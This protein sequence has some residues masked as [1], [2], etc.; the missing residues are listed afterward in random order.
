M[1]SILVTREAR[2][3]TLIESLRIRCN[4]SWRRGL[5]LP[6]LM[7]VVLSTASV[8]L[9]DVRKTPILV[10]ESHTGERPKEIISLVSTLDDELEKRGFAA[11]AA[12]ILQVAA[13]LP[14]PGILDKSITAAQIGQQVEGGYDH[15]VHG[16]YHEA[17]AAE[18]EA[19]EAIQRNPALVVLN[20]S[21]A[22]IVL[23]AYTTLALS[24]AKIGDPD[25]SLTMMQAIRMFPTR[26]FPRA[27]YGPDDEKFYRKVYKQV[28]AMGRGRLLVVAGNSQAV[29]FVDG[30]IRG[31]DKVELADLVPG[32]YRIF[33]QV[34]GTPGRQ[35][36]V[37][38]AANDDTFLNVEP[39]IDASLWVTDSWIGFLFA[40][41]A[42]RGKEAKFAG[43]AAARWSG[44]DLVAVVGTMR[45]AGRLVLT[46]TI[47]T[48]DGT[49]LRSAALDVE[50]A[51][52]ALL[53]SLAHLM[54]E[55]G[56]PADG[57]T[58]ISGG[59]AATK[60]V[61]T[62]AKH[63]VWWTRSAPYVLGGAVLMVGS[64]TLYLASPA[65]GDGSRPTYTDYRGP[66]VVAFAGSTAVFGS[67]LY[68]WLRQ[69]HGAGVMSALAASAGIAMTLSGAMLYVT[70][71]EP[72]PAH[73]TM[74][75]DTGTLGIALGSTGAIAASAGLYFALRG[76]HHRAL[77][78]VALSREHALVSLNASF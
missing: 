27:D 49:M 57:L 14:R 21:N 68:L 28:Q 8:S 73:P 55:G 65:G 40:S 2:M 53:G 45:L 61:S 20:T 18:V 9:A 64:G 76:R 30:Q 19:I 72:G 54:A 31:V 70:R 74:I 1:E 75:R 5:L 13:G 26:P 34:P 12:T 44:R 42:A 63:G 67:G 3:R 39:E 66:A 46:G 33:I 43:G 50:T 41:H 78:V 7:A 6:A 35:Y 56:A 29:V 15:F 62:Q 16:R 48:T 17:V 37:E 58:I 4:G 60:S 25:A 11:H 47:Y 71:E 77:P 10:F 52:P 38:V 36:G 51:T 59:L 69:E 22:D 24:Q 32:P 23:K